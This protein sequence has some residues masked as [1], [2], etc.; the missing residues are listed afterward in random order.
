M[1]PTQQT[2]Q[3]G[4]T[5]IELMIAVAIVAL[6]AAFAVPQYGRYVERSKRTDATTGL[7]KI[8]AELERCYTQFGRYNRADC[9][10]DLVQNGALVEDVS[11]EDLLG[12]IVSEEGDYDLTITGAAQTYVLTATATGSQANDDT[13][14][15]FTLTNIG[16]KSSTPA[17]AA[18]VDN[19]CW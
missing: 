11:H 6:L 15:T 14:D 12:G 18:G 5:L 8:A 13:C 4:F 16:L 17:P 2:T 19:P 1:Q 3:T 10:F 9:T 7:T